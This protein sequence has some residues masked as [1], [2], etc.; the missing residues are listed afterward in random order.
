MPLAGVP[1]A[2]EGRGEPVPLGL[3]GVRERSRTDVASTRNEGKERVC[4]SR[5]TERSRNLPY[6]DCVNKKEREAQKQTKLRC[7]FLSLCLAPGFPLALAPTVHI[8][9]KVS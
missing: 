2:G 5:G 6:R 4:V 9:G 7:H 1:H 3:T 8:L